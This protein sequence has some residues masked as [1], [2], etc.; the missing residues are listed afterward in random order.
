MSDL[1]KSLIKYGLLILTSP[2]WYPFLKAVWQELNTALR[3]DGGLLGKLPS[4]R[5]RA[6]LERNPPLDEDPLVNVPIRRP[7]EKVARGRSAATSARGAEPRRAEPGF[8]RADR[9][10]PKGFR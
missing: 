7:G 4:P 8:G 9:T 6:E 2:I 5:E 1:N 3:A 10:R